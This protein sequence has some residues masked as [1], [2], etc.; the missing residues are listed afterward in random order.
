MKKLKYLAV[1]ALGLVACE[2]EFDNP[3][4]DQQGTFTNGD[5][6]FSRYVSIGNSLTSGFADGALYLHGQENSF[7]NILAGQFSL[8]GGG[9][10]TQPLVNDNLGGLLLGGN[11]IASNR[12]VLNA[13]SSPVPMSG[14]PTTD[15]V[16]ALTGPFNNVGVPGAK[17]YHLLAPGYGNVAGVQLGQANPYYARFAS[18]STSTVFADAMANNP[19][20]FTLWIGNN[21]ILSFATSGGVGVDRLGNTDPS[22]YG[23]NDISDPNVVAGA[24]QTMLTQ[25]TTSGAKGVVCNVPSVT[26][27]PYF[28][29]VP[30]NA[31]PMDQATADA[32]NASYAGYNAIL[33]GLTGVL[34]SPQEAAARTVSFSAGQNAVLIVDEDLTNISAVIQNPPFN[35]PAP[36]A[37]LLA[38]LRP[39]TADDLLVLPSRT[40]I[41]TLADPGNPA[42]VYGV[43]VPLSDEYVL[44]SNEVSMIAT[45]RASY[46][47]SINAVAGA[48]NVP[49][50][51]MKSYLEQLNNSGISFN[52]GIVTSTYATGGGFSLDGV[53][54]TAKG[55]SLI[56]NRIIQTINTSYN[57]NIPEAFPAQYT[58]IFFE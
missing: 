32:T 35:V 26:S 50:V 57:A 54:P 13:Q 2:A 23:A 56:A 12:L 29:T 19:T 9:E 58:T 20:F 51:D 43:G 55:Y 10:F 24:I 41:G 30:Y 42:S 21:D 52:G 7:P 1:L 25:L 39:A 28:T 31:V 36:Q 22:T 48:L 5:A 47:S 11:Q 37:A 18:S 34:I 27:I 38:K 16:N 15:I 44:T 33:T 53:H 4:E 3:V 46:N 40:V 49:V 17:S 14:T 8:V 6:D 45:A